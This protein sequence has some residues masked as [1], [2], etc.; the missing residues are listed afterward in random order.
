MRAD[1]RLRQHNIRRGR[2]G[3]RRRPATGWD[4]LTSTEQ[5]IARLIG[6]GLSNPDIASRMFLSRNT[7]QTHGAAG[8][9]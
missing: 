2:R 4:A 9:R 3:V 7:V 6:E 8:S 5:K 1:T